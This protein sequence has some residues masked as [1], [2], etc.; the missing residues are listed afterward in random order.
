MSPVL[1]LLLQ[2]TAVGLGAGALQ[3]RAML[4]LPSLSTLPGPRSGSG[5]STEVGHPRATWLHRPLESGDMANTSTPR[6]TRE[7]HPGQPLGLPGRK[8]NGRRLGCGSGR[9][10][11]EP[12]P[13]NAGA[14]IQGSVPKACLG[15]DPSPTRETEVSSWTSQ[16]EADSGRSLHSPPPPAV[17]ESWFTRAQVLTRASEDPHCNARE[18]G[19]EG[20]SASSVVIPTR[21]CP[22]LSRRGAM[23]GSYTRKAF[24]DI[25]VFG[26]AYH[27]REQVR[28]MSKTACTLGVYLPGPSWSLLMRSKSELLKCACHPKE[29][30]TYRGF[31]NFNWSTIAYGLPL[32]LN[33]MKRPTSSHTEVLGR[34]AFVAV[35]V[36][37]AVVALT[38][39]LW[40][41]H[42]A[43]PLH[44]SAGAQR[45]TTAGRGYH[46]VPTG[47]RGRFRSCG[48]PPNQRPS[49]AS[50]WM[51]TG[52]RATALAAA[53]GSGGMDGRFCPGDT[54]VLAKQHSDVEGTA[55]GPSTGRLQ[56]TEF[57]NVH[58]GEARRCLGG[59]FGITW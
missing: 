9:R 57:S 34:F 26:L 38:V 12:Q 36:A 11:E 22:G 7:H 35:I 10:R 50:Y 29:A 41:L 17:N 46:V 6:S 19:S 53:H 24:A 30:V 37:A 59:C 2:P 43:A 1:Q 3:H 40:L 28:L 32:R 5:L 49:A 56:V 48:P 21:H 33:E 31:S 47:A 15:L 4:A 25:F 16:C 42:T 52:Q 23:Q 27:W 51:A 55:A 14:Y 18:G 58:A 39:A 20:R 13:E 54:G 44:S 8:R 45:L